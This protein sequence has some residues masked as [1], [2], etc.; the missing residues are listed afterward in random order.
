MQSKRSE[1]GKGH[2]L[3]R[4]LSKLGVCSRAEAWRRIEAGR[5]RLNGVV[6]RDPEQRVRP[7]RDR[8]EVDGRPAAAAAKVYLM[9]NK[10]RGLVTTASDEQG[11]ETVF[12]CLKG[13]EAPH[14][15][16]VGR[17][18]RASEGLLLV[19]NDTAWAAVITD[20][21]SKIPKTYHVQVNAVVEEP[22]L[23]R[24]EAGVPVE[25]ETL[26]ASRAALLRAG[27]KNCWLEIVLDEGKNRHIRRLM[28]GLGLEVLRL[29]RIRVGSLELGSL[30]KGAY[31][32]LTQGEVEAV[33]RGTAHGKPPCHR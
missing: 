10:P 21:E 33:G 22:V 30:A 1:T 11:R 19:T 23:R 6:C 2:G 29:I 4:A 7:G 31:R 20:P 24:M 8:I 15:L 14:L 13:V 27:E 18:D 3:A 28:E 25:G 9:L 32:R 26:S 17:L 16:A 12:E 5:V